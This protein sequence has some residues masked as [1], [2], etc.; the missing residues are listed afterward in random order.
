MAKVRNENHPPEKW[1]I[2][3]DLGLRSPVTQT[4]FHHPKSAIPYTST[5][6]HVITSNTWVFFFWVTFFFVCISFF[7]WLP[8]SGDGVS[9]GFLRE[10]R[11][12]PILPP[13]FFFLCH[14]VVSCSSC[15]SVNF[16]MPACRRAAI[17]PSCHHVVC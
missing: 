17:V 13:F 15:D 11:F 8:L 12:P 16:I 5:V 1:K 14:H 2:S 6:A 3:D 4:P 9:C 7:H 10:A